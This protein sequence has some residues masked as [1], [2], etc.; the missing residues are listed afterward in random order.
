MG[1]NSNP[2][3]EPK[4]KYD[5]T[6][7]ALSIGVPRR[8]SVPSPRGTVPTT[9][10]VN[11]RVIQESLASYAEPLD[12]QGIVI[13]DAATYQA[14]G[15]ILVE[16]KTKA[17]QAT[18]ERDAML[19]PMKDA[20]KRVT[21]FFA[22][23]LSALAASEA[24]LKR[25]MVDYTIREEARK[26]ELAAKAQQLLR[27]APPTAPA[28]QRAA[29]INK[30]MALVEQVNEAPA[31]AAGVSIRKVWKAHVVDPSKVPGE[32]WVIDERLINADAKARSWSNPPP[33]VEYYQETSMAAAGK[34][35]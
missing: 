2:P 35:E 24:G 4:P 16:I 32:F 15:E 13:E 12:V 6:N 28:P 27:A 33:G 29:A 10:T 7:V 19:K 8:P 21:A 22:P 23:A 3:K 11:E 5:P 18:A 17:K 30:A 25:A 14:M 31:M 1:T 9:V 34:K 20:V 26:R